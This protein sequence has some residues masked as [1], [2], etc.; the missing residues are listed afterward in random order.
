MDAKWFQKKFAG[1]LSNINR[2]TTLEELARAEDERNVKEHQEGEKAVTSADTT[3]TSPSV[4]YSLSPQEKQTLKDNLV[5]YTEILLRPEIQTDGYINQEEA[6]AQAQE[7]I[8]AEERA[9]AK[10][11]AAEAERAEAEKARQEALAKGVEVAPDPPKKT[12]ED[13]VEGGTGGVDESP[14][15]S[16]LIF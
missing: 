13:S 16:E 3:A 9:K 2:N 4:H 5:S 1:I 7:Q 14:G 15:T 8:L 12:G 11:L 10:A 6:L